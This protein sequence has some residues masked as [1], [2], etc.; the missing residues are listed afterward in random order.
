MA[1]ETEHTTD[2]TSVSS[3][4]PAPT[5]RPEDGT[6]VTSSGVGNGEPPKQEQVYGDLA[7]MPQLPRLL[8]CRWSLGWL[9][10]DWPPLALWGS[11]YL[12]GLR[13]GLGR[14]A[15]VPPDYCPAAR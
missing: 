1:D 5:W 2:T 4:S 15:V 8:S 6:E 3:P 7:P 9:W 10:R 12:A 13:A 14:G 11:S